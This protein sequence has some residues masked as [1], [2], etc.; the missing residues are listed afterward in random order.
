[1]KK[2]LFDK[3]SQACSRKTTNVYSTSF[4]LGTYLLGKEYRDPIYSIYGFVRFA[5]EIVDSFHGYDKATL[6]R[7]FREDTILAI[8]DGISLNPILNSFQDTVNKYNIEWQLIETFLESMKQDLEF[9]EYDRDKFDQYILGSAEVVGL[10]CLRVFTEGDEQYYQRLKPAAM[11]LGAAFQKV[12]FLRD[13]QE[14]FE[15]LGRTYFP[16][17]DLTKFTEAEKRQIEGE[18][19]SDFREALIGIRGLPSGARRGVYIAYVYYKRLFDKIKSLPPEQILESR[20]R[21]PNGQKMGIMLR[22]LI[23]HQMNLL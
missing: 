4:S 9:V 15:G 17:L 16:G 6:L 7:R 3:V 13:A 21:I 12:N 23:Q 5:D 1:M 19:E 8:A 22:S 18:I 2:E 20:I 14:D 10:M 11:K